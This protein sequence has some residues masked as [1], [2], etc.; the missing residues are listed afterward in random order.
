MKLSFNRWLIANVLAIG[1][2][3]AFFVL[4]Y[5]LLQHEVV[6]PDL[7]RAAGPLVTVAGSLSDYTSE[8][9]PLIQDKTQTVEAEEQ[10]Q[11]IEEIKPE[12]S[13]KRI[14]HQ[15]LRPRKS[16]NPKNRRIKRK[17]RRIKRK[18]AQK[19]PKHEKKKEL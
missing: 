13:R 5:P 6:I 15:R 12:G 18:K 8:V 4:L 17:N 16:Q 9:E 11:K 19:K 2:N 10:A 3:V 1:I 7:E 14:G